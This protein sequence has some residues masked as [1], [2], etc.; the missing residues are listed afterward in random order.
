MRRLSVRLAELIGTVAI[1]LLAAPRGA[2]AKCAAPQPVVSPASGSRLPANPV[3]YVFWPRYSADK[4]PKLTAH[5]GQDRPVSLSQSLI[6]RV[7]AFAVYQV[8][9]AVARP[10][11]VTLRAA[12]EPYSFWGVDTWQF[13][14]DAG[15]RAPA[16]PR[17]AQAL[18]I[19]EARSRWV[20]SYQLSQNLTTPAA[21]S[22]FRVAIADSA[23][24]YAAGRLRSLVL[25]PHMAMFFGAGAGGRD[26]THRRSELQLGHSNCIGSTWSWAAKPIYVGV[27]ALQ[28]DG[29]EAPIG[30]APVRVDPPGAAAASSEQ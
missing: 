30:T 17:P 10:G 25:P 18:A 15:W 5:D 7:E 1:V 6:A 8:K 13:T 16:A 21:A 22:A 29:S 23:Q 26:N 3:L 11:A 9:L 2:A 12:P 20:C 19:T 4:P 27:F 24:D 28:A 14:I